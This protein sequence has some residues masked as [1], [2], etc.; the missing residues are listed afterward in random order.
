LVR[1]NRIK[2]YSTGTLTA[3]A[4]GDVAHVSDRAL[5]GVLHS[6]EIDF[7]TSASADVTVYN[8]NFSGDSGF[9]Y[10]F[11]AA[12]GDT[13]LYPKIQNTKIADGD[14]ITSTYGELILKNKVGFDVTAAGSGSGLSV[15]VN[16][17]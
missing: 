1:D 14:V 8:F 12:T 15:Q 13:L 4:G 16:Y 9:N 11:V 5:N 2:A 17:I 3:A 10:S 7:G 6:I